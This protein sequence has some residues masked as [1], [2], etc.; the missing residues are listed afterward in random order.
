MD[1]ELKKALEDMNTTFH[2]FK[3]ANDNRMKELELKN[4][5]DVLTTEK[6]SRINDG[7]DKLEQMAEDISALQAKSN[8]PGAG[9]GNSEEVTKEEKASFDDFLR[10]GEKSALK[11][12]QTKAGSTTTGGWGAGIPVDVSRNIEARLAKESS[13]R[14]LVTVENRGSTNVTDLLDMGGANVGWRGEGDGVGATGTPTLTPVTYPGGMIYALPSTTEESFDD[15]FFDVSAWLQNSAVEGFGEEESAVIMSGNG[16]D[17]PKGLLTYTA[18]ATDDDSRASGQFQ[19]VASG[20]A[21][22][23]AND[24]T[25]GDAFIDVEAEL[26]GRYLRNA[27]YGMHRKTLR[28]IRKLKDADG[29]YIYQPAMTDGTP[30]QINGYG[31]KLLDDMPQ[32]A[33]GAL[34]VAFGDWKKAYKLIPIVVCGSCAMM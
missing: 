22:S 32:E 29:V 4:S 18:V 33:A 14:D 25:T 19:F 5:A 12:I 6:L 23:I 11:K 34:S 30:A 31:Y 26:H 15:L 7:M 28:T 1:P 24:T 13:V 27:Q 21:A 16:T 10:T 9:G 20:I 8:R 17:K 3:A 2:E